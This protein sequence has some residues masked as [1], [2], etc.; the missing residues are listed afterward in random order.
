LTADNYQGFDDLEAERW[1]AGVVYTYGPGMTFRGS[2]QFVD[3]DNVEDAEGLAG[4]ITDAGKD[5]VD[6]TSILLGTQINF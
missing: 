2:V 1:T 4:V 5:S 3:F 6:A